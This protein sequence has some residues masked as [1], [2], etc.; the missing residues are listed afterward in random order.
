MNLPRA[1]RL[2]AIVFLAAAFLETGAQAQ[3]TVGGGPDF[4]SYAFEQGLGA[5]AAQLFLFP[6]AVRFPATSALAI[7]VY[8]AWAEGRVE[9]AD[10]LYKLSGPVDTGL[11]ASY[12]A[13]P[14]ALVTLGLNLPTGDAARDGEEAIVASLLATDLLGFREASWGRGFAV[15]PSVAVARGMG[16][17]GLG[18]AAAYAVRG[19]F[20]PSEDD[21]ALEYQPGNEARIRLGLD[22]N[23]GNS[24]LTLG[25]TFMSYTSDQA[26][27]QN[28]L[29]AG[30][31]FRFDA[32]YAFRMGAGVWTLY[33]ADLIRQNGTLT[34]PN[35]D[36]Q[37]APLGT[38]SDVDTPKQNLALLG[39]T[40]TLE[41]GGGFVF[42]PHVDF[43]LQARED[44]SGSDAGLGWLVS[45]GGDIP[46]RIFGG[47]DFF[48]KASIMIGS[49]KDAT[50][51]GVRVFGLEAKGTIRATF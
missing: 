12:Q 38:F 40:G 15:T 32:T 31:R 42:R 37:G 44:T 33:A 19:T 9:R 28:L 13:T 26:N 23:F 6:V 36:P 39:F 46:I 51:D 8:G 10:T 41:L 49:L 35:V 17:F 30:R 14:W 29:Q 45:A 4:T 21:T 3:V 5:D 11:R 25:G 27:G 18:L 48:P 20:N 22:R 16:N 24:T 50:G 7:D 2:A 1:R 34:L 47:H 43:K